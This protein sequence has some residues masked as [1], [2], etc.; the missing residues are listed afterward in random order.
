[1][2]RHDSAGLVEV[3]ERVSTVEK[4][5]GNVERIECRAG[6]TFLIPP[7]VLRCRCSDEAWRRPALSV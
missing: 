1:M 3:S 6:L 5:A 4:L 7:L 2:V